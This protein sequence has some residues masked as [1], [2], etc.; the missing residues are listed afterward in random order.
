MRNEIN[1]GISRI[2]I[3]TAYEVIGKRIIKLP[4]RKTI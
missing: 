4:N 1:F 2:G 3:T